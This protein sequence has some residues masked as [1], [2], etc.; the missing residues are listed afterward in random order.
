MA[1]IWV[2]TGSYSS[3]FR[4]VFGSL[5]LCCSEATS[6]SSDKQITAVII[7]PRAGC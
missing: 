5:E 4:N 3:G 1:P 2:F 6:E 7:T